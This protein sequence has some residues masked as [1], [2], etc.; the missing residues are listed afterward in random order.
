M[1]KR[2]FVTL[3]AVIGIVCVSYALGQY[4]NFGSGSGGDPFS[5]P[6]GDGDGWRL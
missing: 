5:N 1:S 2:L 6:F 4:S 3:L